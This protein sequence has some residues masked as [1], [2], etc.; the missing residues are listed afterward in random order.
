MLIKLCDKEIKK[1]NVQEVIDNIE[2]NILDSI[3][4]LRSAS[5]IFKILSTSKDDSFWYSNEIFN[6]T[7]YFCSKLLELRPESVQ[8]K[9]LGFFKTDSSSEHFFKQCHEYIQV[10]MDKLQNGTLKDFY[11]RH[12]Y[13]DELSD[14]C[15]LVDK[16]LEKQVVSLFRNFCLHDNKEMQNY[17]REQVNN[18]K[19]YNMTVSIT[20]YAS[21]FLGHLQFPVAFDTFN[22]TL[23]WVLELIQGPNIVNQEIVIQQGFIQVA[24]EILKMEYNEDQIVDENTSKIFKN[25]IPL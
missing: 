1:S 21:K 16:N 12:R 24:N 10:H 6:I 20:N 9:F 19:N 18:T 13:T 7:A 22:R 2:N 8:E 23:E 11:S 4:T 3:D 14:S 5:M 25:L 17:L 15:Y